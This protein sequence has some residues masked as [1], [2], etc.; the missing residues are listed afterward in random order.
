M[1]WQ[2]SKFWEVCFCYRFTR[3]FNIILGMKF[4]INHESLYDFLTKIV[5]LQLKAQGQG[6]VL[7]I[8]GNPE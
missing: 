4:R 5:K 7:L 6:C 8:G 2:K 3:T 1:G